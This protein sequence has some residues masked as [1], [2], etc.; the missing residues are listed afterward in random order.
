MNV[1]VDQNVNVESNSTLIK[2][3]LDFCGFHTLPLDIRFGA[4]VRDYQ[5]NHTIHRK[6]HCKRNP[7]TH[8]CMQ[9]PI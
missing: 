4:D 5:Y 8:T 9:V 1:R 7:H 6:F 3:P 2:N